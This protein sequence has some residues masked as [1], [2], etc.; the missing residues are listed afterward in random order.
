MSQNTKSV[1]FFPHLK[2]VRT[3]LVLLKGRPD[4]EDYLKS[5]GCSAKKLPICPTVKLH[6]ERSQHILPTRGPGDD[7]P[8]QDDE[9]VDPD[10]EL[11]LRPETRPILHDQL[12]GL[13][14]HVWAVGSRF[15]IEFTA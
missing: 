3:S 1:E 8:E 13:G 2:R 15:W 12:F 14:A 10:P 6:N 11:L 5:R 7:P 9:W 4:D